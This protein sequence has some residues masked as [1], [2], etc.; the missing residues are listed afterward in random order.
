MCVCVWGGG[1]GVYVCVCV[2]VCVCV[3]VQGGGG[4]RGVKGAIF[5]HQASLKRVLMHASGVY[6]PIFGELLCLSTW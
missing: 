1:V 3:C 4:G 6:M 2:S 5:L